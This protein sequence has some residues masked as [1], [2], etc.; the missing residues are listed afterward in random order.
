M[1]QLEQID[2]FISQLFWLVVT[3]VP[4]YLILWRVALPRISATLEDRQQRIDSD[5]SRANELAEQAEEVMSAYEGQLAKA[6]GNA[7]EE[8]HA[9]AVRAAA[10]AEARNDSLSAQIAHNSDE[11]RRRIAAARQAATGSIA[12]VAQELAAEAAERLI[13]KRPEASSVATAVNAAL[14]ENG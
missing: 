11:A 10:E 4:L 14:K 6:R 7:Q 5:L 12:D 2:T 9:A 8:L 13:G 1:P 3:F